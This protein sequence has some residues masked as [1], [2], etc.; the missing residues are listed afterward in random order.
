MEVFI[1]GDMELIVKRGPEM[2]INHRRP[3]EGHG[4]FRVHRVN[5]GLGCH[6]KSKV[7]K[8][9]KFTPQIF[10]IRSKESLETKILLLGTLFLSELGIDIFTKNTKDFK[11]YKGR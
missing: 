1:I 10:I 7:S 4:P 11:D 9:I 2:A 3:K 6:Q 5:R 8:H